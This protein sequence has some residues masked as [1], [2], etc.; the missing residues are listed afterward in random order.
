[1]D[2]RLRNG[3]YLIV[4]EGH[5]YP[6]EVNVDATISYG[7]LIDVSSHVKASDVNNSS[8]KTEVCAIKKT[9][10]A[11]KSHTLHK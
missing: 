1:M 7:R 6:S 4:G 2:A 11:S 3:L 5:E 9:T 8:R 10:Q